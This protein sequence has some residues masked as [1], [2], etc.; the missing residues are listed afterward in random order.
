M[1]ARAL[2][3]KGVFLASRIGPVRSALTR[4]YELAYRNDPFALR[5]PFDV[6]HRIDASGCRPGSL[7]HSGQRA[8][9][10]VTGY[11]GS[12]PSTVERIVRE[13]DQPRD[14]AFIDVGCGKGRVLAIASRL[15]FRRVIGIE[16]SPELCRAA[17]EN[18]QRL[19]QSS[20][21]GT[22]IEVVQ[23]NAADYAMPGGNL[24]VF[25]YNPFGAEV[26]AS[27]RRTLEAA[28]RTERRDIV[29]AYV[30][31]T[32]GDILDGMDGFCCTVA[33]W[34]PVAEQELPFSRYERYRV[35]VWRNADFVTAPSGASP[36]AAAG[37]AA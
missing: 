5:H 4:L 24:L 33:E 25:L 1:D 32:H 23:K 34:V 36:N 18:S 6:E 20:P 26:M 17:V 31:P 21:G 22:G 10:H 35:A 29:I 9:R 13:I 2:V 14:Y 19:A 16:M 12:Q 27:F 11:A 3:H 8:D 30:Q 15:G 37:W 7:L 28:R